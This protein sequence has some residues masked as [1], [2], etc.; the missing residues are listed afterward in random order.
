VIEASSV[1]E[2]VD[3]MVDRLSESVRSEES[4]LGLLVNNLG[5]VPTMEMGVIVNEVVRSR[6]AP[7]IDLVFGPAPLMTSLDM[8]GF[9][10]SLIELNDARREALLSAAE[11]EAWLPGARL[12]PRTILPLPGGVASRVFRGS[13]NDETAAL[14]QRICGVLIENEAELNALDARVGDGDTGSTFAAAARAVEERLLASAL[15]LA[16]SDQ[17]CLA[18]GELLAQTM[19]GSSGVLLSIFF[20]AAGA[21]MKR[22]SSLRAAFGRAVAA[23]QEYGGAR[24]GD[25]TMLDALVPAFDALEAGSLDAAAAAAQRGAEATASM[26]HARAGRSSYLTSANLA[27]V[28]DPGATAVALA[29][30]AAAQL[31]S[32][33][34]SRL[35]AC[36]S[37]AEPLRKCGTTR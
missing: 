35:P 3:L 8:N 6:L 36:V 18:V 19:G 9:S 21:E 26:T 31:D 32:F 4:R 25:R 10:L 37:D 16:D 15:P 34:E 22:T 5:G 12:E 29:F 11:P 14:V 17:L 7:R 1:K 30:V 27:G 2:I 13:A 20:T 33:D 28:R 23:V 24:L